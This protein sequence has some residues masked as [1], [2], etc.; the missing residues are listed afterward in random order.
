MRQQQADAWNA[1]NPAPKTIDDEKHLAL[2]FLEEFSFNGIATIRWYENQWFHWAGRW[3]PISDVELENLVHRTSKRYLEDEIQRINFEAL[4]KDPLA[5]LRVVPK[6]GRNGVANVMLALRVEVTAKESG[7]VDGR[8][9]RWIAFADKILNLNAW[10]DGEVVTELQTPEYFAP[11]ALD[12]P[13]T[14]TE[15]EPTIFLDML[16][17]QFA[18]DP[19]AIDILQEFGGYCMTDETDLQFSLYIV[20]PP[21]SGKGTYDRTLRTTVGPHNCASKQM[22]S[23]LGPHALENLPFKN[24]LSLSDTRPDPNVSRQGS[25]RLLSIIGQDPMDINPKGKTVYTKALNCKVVL[26]SNVLADFGDPSGAMLRR[27]IL[28]Q[29]TV[30]HTDDADPKLLEKILSQ[31]NEV[32]WWFLRGLQ[33]LMKNQ[34]YTQPKNNLRELFEIKNNPVQCFGKACLVVTGSAED[35]LGR[36]SVYSAF[37]EWAEDKQISGM[38]RNVF[39][40]ELYAAFPKI[41][42]SKNNVS[43]VKFKEATDGS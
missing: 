32:C 5:K 43:G 3:G 30:G 27:L 26:M 22:V 21:G 25:E 39:F 10:I 2:V 40:R 35:K 29:T 6:F 28:V 18:N 15:D 13:L 20:G 16:R 7:W 33:R 31:Q 19:S 38:D 34:K 41:R 24:L 14:Y 42:P 11:T 23:F 8:G 17:E 36:E 1:N 37:E 9:G 4:R 12:Y